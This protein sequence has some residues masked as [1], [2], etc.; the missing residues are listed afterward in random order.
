MSSPRSPALL[1][2]AAAA[3]LLPAATA[4]AAPVERFVA[5][6]RVEQRTRWGEPELDTTVGCDKVHRERHGT[7][8]TTLRTQPVRVRFR[9]LPGGAAMLA[10]GSPKRPQPGLEGTGTVRRT[11]VFESYRENGPCTPRPGFTI[12]REDDV[13]A[14]CDGR[15]RT[16]VRFADPGRSFRPLFVRARL[17]EL[18]SVLPCDVEFPQGVKRPLTGIEGTLSAARVFGRDEYVIVRGRKTF[19]DTFEQGGGTTMTVTW[20]LRMRRAR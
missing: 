16:L 5:F 12:G 11:Y 15:F 13:D 9:R 4:G 3:L 2:A 10:F 18:G 7:D 19:R 14:D 1:V 8:V 6:F 20:T 17:L